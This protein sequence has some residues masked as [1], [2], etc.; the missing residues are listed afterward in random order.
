MWTIS[1]KPKF[2][3]F[4]KKTEGQ[5]N[6]IIGPLVFFRIFPKSMRDVYMNKLTL[7]LIKY[8]I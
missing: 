6:Q 2:G 3:H 7:I 4:S 8:S 1:E 5:K